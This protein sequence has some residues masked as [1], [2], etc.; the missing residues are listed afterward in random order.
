MNVG[1]SAASTA[2]LSALRE[3]RVLLRWLIIASAGVLV[4]FWLFG[5]GLWLTSQV[6][7]P[8]FALASLVTL[9][10]L[11]MYGVA[12][13]LIRR[14]QTMLGRRWLFLAMTSG[15]AM[16]LLLFGGADGARVVVLFVPIVSA[17]LLGSG[18]DT[19]LVSVVGVLVYFG[20]L[21]GEQFAQVQPLL[22]D[23]LVVDSL[24]LVLTV[25]AIGTLAW[26]SS[27]DLSRALAESHSRA[28]ELLRNTEQLMEKNIQQVELG[29]ELAAAAAEL[30]ANS[31]QQAGG[32]S[33]QASAVSEVSTTIE[34]LGSTARQIAQAAEHVSEAAQ[35]TL[36]QLSSGQDAVDESIQ[37]MERIRQRVQDISTRVLGLGER[38]QQIGEII[39]LIDDISDETHLLALNAA[40]EAAGAGEYGRRFAVV[41]AEVKSLANRTLAAAKEVK[42]VIAEIRQATSAAVLAAEEGSKEV[43]RGVELAHRAGQVMDNIV[44]VAERTAQAAAEIGLAT[45]QQQSA[46][47]Q[48]VE[49][50]REI[51]EVARQSALSARQMAESAAKLTAIAARLHGIANVDDGRA[52]SQRGR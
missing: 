14:Q 27:R 37:A 6:A 48:V 4:A 26:L 19:L 40:I 25:C 35:Q 18:R 46:S 50:M 34:E 41:A 24:F 38:S 2:E 30:Q 31:Q 20:L 32:A 29:S 52:V 16:V 17:G 47:E 51:A 44:M 10:G 11:A 5:L 1:M 22:A 7:M 23:N 43:E 15:A 21:A 42:G 8:P 39:D 12:G 36:E 9:F 28:E 49:T 45:A 33:E 3:N 13:W